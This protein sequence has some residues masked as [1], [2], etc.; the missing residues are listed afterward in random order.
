MCVSERVC[1]SVCVCVCLQEASLQQVQLE[2]KSGSDLEDL[3]QRVVELL[4][5]V[6]TDCR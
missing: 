5:Q 4:D 3:E 2:V 1:V 6:I